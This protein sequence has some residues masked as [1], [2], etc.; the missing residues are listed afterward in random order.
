MN[1]VPSATMPAVPANLP[2]A[3]GARLPATY[4]AAQQAL[5]ECDKIDE[6]KSWADKAAALASYARMASDETLWATAQRIH[7]RAIRRCGELLKQQ[8][9]ANGARTDLGT[10]P[11]RGSFADAA[12]MSE[13]QRK[14]AL[15]VANVPRD[16]F[17][18]QVDSVQPP[19]VT[20]LA[21]QGICPSGVIDPNLKAENSVV[22]DGY[23]LVEQ[24]AT[25][26]QHVDAAQ[27]AWAIPKAD[28]PALLQAIGGIRRWLAV[29]ESNL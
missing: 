4:A 1:L 18:R 8:A 15:R 27:L 25:R 26:M 17:E 29:L 10:V 11:T 7:A 23:H 20:D 2:D 5:A 13:R 3:S 12:G 16:D 19:T 21:R 9:P 14:T 22:S 6:C 28:K 24:L